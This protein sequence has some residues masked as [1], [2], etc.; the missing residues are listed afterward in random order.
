ML[1]TVTTSS[2]KLTEILTAAQQDTVTRLRSERRPH[3]VIIQ[4][5]H[6]SVDVYVEMGDDATVAGGFK[7]VANGGLLTY[8]DMT[9]DNIRLIADGGNNNNIRILV[10]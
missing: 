2:Q 9:L 7:I 8:E 1:I 4:N 6:A 5:L 3:Q 10:D